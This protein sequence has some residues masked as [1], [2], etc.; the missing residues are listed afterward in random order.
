MV[1]GDLV[2]CALSSGRP[3]WPQ[4]PS[5]RWQIPYHTFDHIPLKVVEVDALTGEVYLTPDERT[6][7]LTEVER[8]ATIDA[9]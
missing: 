8:L 3:I 7:L 2:G 6:A 5:P 9:V 4:I 1:F